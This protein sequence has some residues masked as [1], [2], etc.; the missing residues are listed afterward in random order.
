MRALLPKD[1]VATPTFRDILRDSIVMMQPFVYRTSLPPKSLRHRL[2]MLEH[3]LRFDYRL[4]HKRR[5]LEIESASDWAF[6]FE[7]VLPSFKGKGGVRCRGQ[8]TV[9][10]ASGMTVIRGKVQCNQWYKAF[11]AAILLAFL[12]SIFPIPAEYRA[13]AII[14]GGLVGYVISHVSISSRSA[15]HRLLKYLNT[16]IN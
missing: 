16:I 2:T 10:P 4:G 7:I 15:P 8:V 1:V 9:D 14:G 13:M 6:D 11:Q 5:V 12:M 3:Q